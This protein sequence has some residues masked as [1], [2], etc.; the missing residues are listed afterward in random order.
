MVVFSSS[1]A[2]TSFSI[3][4]SFS[5]INISSSISPKVFSLAFKLTY[6]PSISTGDGCC[7]FNKVVADASNFEMWLRYPPRIRSFY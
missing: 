3:S 2:T 4:F 5:N 1:L 7:A 6:K